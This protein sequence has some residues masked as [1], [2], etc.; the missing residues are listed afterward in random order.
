MSDGKKQW[1]A[2]L[3]THVELDAF[4]ILTYYVWRWAIEVFFKDAKQIL[5]LGKA[6]TE[7]FDAVIACYSIVMMGYLLLFYVLNKYQLTGPIGSLSK[8]L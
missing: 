4:A 6:Q 5:Y 2:F 3:S 8:S 7:T 1:P